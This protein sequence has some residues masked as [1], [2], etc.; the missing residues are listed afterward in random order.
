MNSSKDFLFC[1][2]PLEGIRKDV[3]V[4]FLKHLL[5]VIQI[6]SLVLLKRLKNRS[7]TFQELSAPKNTETRETGNITLKFAATCIFCSGDYYGRVFLAGVKD[8]FLFDGKFS[9]WKH[10]L[11]DQAML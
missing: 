4:C 8:F 1:F 7:T 10:C 11:N 9:D 2:L 3:S 6:S 5:N